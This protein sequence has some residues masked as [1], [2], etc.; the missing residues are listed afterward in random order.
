M[1]RVKRITRLPESLGEVDHT[2]LVRE[3]REAAGVL[4][5]LDGEHVAAVVPHE[6]CGQSCWNTDA[7]HLERLVGLSLSKRS[8]LSCVDL[9]GK[10]DGVAAPRMHRRLATGRHLGGIEMCR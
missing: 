4:C 6:L 3:H 9:P 1:F 8:R 5:C 7:E 2:L 10:L